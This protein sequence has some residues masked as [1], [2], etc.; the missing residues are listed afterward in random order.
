[1]LVHN[2]R[3]A[4]R[5]L[6]R[7]PGFTFTVVLTLALAIGANGAVF[8]ALDAVL[9]K[10]L[11][12]P[13][14][15]RLVRLTQSA[16]DGPPSGTAPIR[17]EDWN[18]LSSTFE[19]ITGFY[20]EDVS[21][22][23]GETPE[24]VRR[25]TVAPR[26][27]EVW[28]VAPV[29]GR[30]FS[31][32]DHHGQPLT[33]L[34]SERYWRT[35]LGAEPNVIGRQLRIGTGTP[36]VI[37]VMPASFLFPDRQ[38]DVWFPA[39]IDATYA[40][41]RALS[42]YPAI[43]R[44][45]PGATLDEARANL[46]VVQ[47]QL[48]AQYPETDAN[49]RVQ[50][51]P[52]KDGIV[53]GARGSL[54][55]L[56]G[57]ASLLLL[58]AC[59][60]IAT[61]L[62][63][64]GAERRREVAVRLSLG[65]RP[66]RIAGQWLTETA[67]LATAGASGGLL[68]A[69]GATGAL[70]ALSSNVPRLDEIALDGRFVL[71]TI[72]AVAVVTLL[73][74]M[75]PALRSARGVLAGEIAR[76]SRAQVS[77]RQSLHWWLVGT[78]VAL[79]V[80]LL[81]G[82]GLLVRSIQELGRVDAG[83]ERAHVLTFRVSAAFADMS[84]DNFP[85]FQQRYATTLEALAALPGVESTATTSWSPPGV[86]TAFEQEYE[87]PA[88]RVSP[89]VRVLAE[90][91]TVSPSYFATLGIPLVEGALCRLGGGFG[92]GDVLVNKSFLQRYGRGAELVGARIGRA[93]L[94]AGATITGVVGDVRERGLDQPPAPTVYFCNLAGS[95]TP[96]VLVR[97]R[98]DPD[99]VVATVRAKMKELE[100]LRAVFSIASLEEQIG[101][102]FAENR[103]RTVVLAL[104]AGAA[105]A[106][107]CLGLYGTLSYVVSLRRREVGLRLAL[108]ALQGHIV[109]QFVSKALRVVGVACVVGL[110]LSFASARALQGMLFGVSATD[111]VT[112]AAV[113]GIV[114]G[115]GA[116]AAFLPALRAARLDPMRTLR[117]E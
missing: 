100:P 110:A 24:M 72:A 8:S 98:G 50:V 7:S 14:G 10:P 46:A 68:L 23:T 44:L 42:W 34:V 31:E 40:Q 18:R 57:A 1:M 90:E 26:F 70:R 45:K 27:T 4:C 22:A 51:E 93:Q 102:A 47:A 77:T 82:A 108:G 114:V 49:L 109:G 97:T 55:L 99:A 11:P 52:Y 56:F 25:A 80:A 75:L 83:F 95:P 36:R 63:T 6:F 74:G 58:I 73:C 66:A 39:P 113:V 15:D 17:V 19:A 91:R 92:G 103:L 61:L 54:W 12:F 84:G 41:S 67:V 53:A 2:L 59:T 112:L 96:F 65:A 3:Y 32:E 16:G 86:P 89:D 81:A 106:L 78:Q 88:G 116:L 21:D 29:L 28:G 37:G 101:D 85:V 71:Y 76:G 30:G 104:F 105:L 79:S 107:A 33:V 38:T 13:N 20:T 111:P 5:S 69:K 94:P 62:L 48:G 43:G 64:R 35:R 9:F 117:E 87:L 115:V 60:N